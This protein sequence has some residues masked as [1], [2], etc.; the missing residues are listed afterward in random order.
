MGHRVRQLHL[1]VD[2]E[3]QRVHGDGVGEDE[4]SGVYRGG[5]VGVWNQC[6]MA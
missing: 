3:A 1:C 6:I 4:K 5:V 2:S